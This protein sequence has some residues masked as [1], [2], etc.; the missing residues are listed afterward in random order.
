MARYN[1]IECDVLRTM[2]L[3]YMIHA[4]RSNICDLEPLGGVVYVLYACTGPL[5]EMVKIGYSTHFVNRIQSL[6]SHYPG[7]MAVD[8][9]IWCDEPQYVEGALH[10]LFHECRVECNYGIEWFDIEFE[11]YEWL[12]SL[13]AISGKWIKHL[14]KQRA[15]FL[16]G[17]AESRAY[18]KM[19]LGP[20]AE[21][22]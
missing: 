8:H 16:A 1:G 21:S 7:D 17:E 9:V 3:R 2:D 5:E 6:R 19:D 10:C 15:A 4:A 11:D 22:L 18:T 12:R 14:K 20:F 13:N